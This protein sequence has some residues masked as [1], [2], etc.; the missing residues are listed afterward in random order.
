VLLKQH[1]LD[2]ASQY[3]DE[4]V[5]NLLQNEHPQVA[6]A[7]ALRAK[8]LAVRG[9]EEPL[10]LGHEGLTDE[11][12]VD[13]ANATAR[14]ADMGEPRVAR[15][16]F[17]E[18]EPIL[19]QR[20]GES[21]PT[22]LQ[23][24]TGLAN[25]DRALG[26]HAERAATL[27]RILRIQESSGD[28]RQAIDTLNAIAL[29]RSESRDFAAA[30]AA[31]QRALQTAEQAADLSAQSSVLRNYG[32]FL[33]EVERKDEALPRLEAALA[34]AKEAGDATLVGTA[35]VALGILR[36]HLGDLEQA[37]LLLK[38]ACKALDPLSTD[39]L[40]G[41][42]HLTAIETGAE[43]GCNE[44]TMT[45]AVSQAIQEYV[46]QRLPLG[47]TV[48]VDVAYSKE[49]KEWLVSVKP[50][51]ETT[52]QEQAEI[53]RVVEHALAHFRAQVGRGALSPKPRTPRK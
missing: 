2:E 23:T 50:A 47:M 21:H 11:Q 16:V 19:E 4:A 1:K 13:L 9:S 12:L 40:C 5:A 7:M 18:L 30:E 32:L 51:R 36:Q 25:L 49:D 35:Q 20:L 14:R 41:R 26:N 44:A 6:S 48:N 22:T 37:Q 27:E 42:S 34:K 33:A 28:N 29:A 8:I 43:D 31:Y 24:L 17:A 52:A 10:F 46:Q 38:A 53:H 3:A 15:N 39:A 45:L